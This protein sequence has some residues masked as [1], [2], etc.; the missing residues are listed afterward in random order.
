V[1]TL[2][3]SPADAPAQV[4]GEDKEFQGEFYPVAKP[5]HH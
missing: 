4:D 5:H 1:P 3:T 2:V